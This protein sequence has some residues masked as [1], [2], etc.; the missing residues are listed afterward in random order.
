VRAL[1]GEFGCSIESIRAWVK[2]AN[3]DAGLPIVGKDILSTTEREELAQLRRQVRQL[4][5]E[6]DI[7]AKATAWFAQSGASAPAN[8]TAS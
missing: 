6:R 1:A 5:A 2:R 4:K 7:L 3:K 8:F